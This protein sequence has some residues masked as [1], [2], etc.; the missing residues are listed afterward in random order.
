MKN[1]LTTWQMKLV[2]SN[3]KL[4]VSANGPRVLQF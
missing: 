1:V 2:L 4:F 3:F